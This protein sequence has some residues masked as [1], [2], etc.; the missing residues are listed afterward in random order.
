MSS[1]RR[2]IAVSA[3]FTLFGGPGIVLF[4]LPLWMTRFRIPVGEPRWQLLLGSGLIAV[5]LT[6]GLESV[7]RFV[8][9]GRGTLLPTTPPENLV[10][11]GFYRYVRNPMYVGVLV[12]LAGEGIL[13]WSRGLLVE[14]VL[15]FIGFNLFVRL[16]EEPFLARRHPQEYPLYKSHVPRW[17]PRLT[18]WTGPQA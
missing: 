8:F 18:P 15:A 16:H 7:V 5:G 14:E 17:L 9:V 10:V 4:F 2:N 6:P 11:S 12:A 13:F 1:H 3:L